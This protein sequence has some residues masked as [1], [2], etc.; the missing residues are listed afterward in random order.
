MPKPK[1]SKVNSIEKRV[2]EEDFRR[3][4][5]MTERKVGRELKDEIRPRIL[6]RD[7]Y[8]CR[9]C[10]RVGSADELKIDHV[11]PLHLGGSDSDENRQT[12][13]VTCHDAK[14]LEETKGRAG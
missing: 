10:S 4:V 7:G 8:R 13:C 6:L 9:V 1:R 3:T 2:K 11:F 5:P 12:L 14:T